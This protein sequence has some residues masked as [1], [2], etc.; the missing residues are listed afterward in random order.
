LIIEIFIVIPVTLTVRKK[1]M[2][3]FLLWNLFFDHKLNSLLHW[4]G[5]GWVGSEFSALTLLVW[6]YDL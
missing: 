5:W 1:P 6:S 3:Q 4:L 2:I